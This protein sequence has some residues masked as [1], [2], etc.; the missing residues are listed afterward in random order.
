MSP[1][2]RNQLNPRCAR[3][4]LPRRSALSWLRTR[5]SAISGHHRR[6]PGR[7]DN[8][9]KNHLYSKLRRKF[10]STDP[11]SEEAKAEEARA[12]EAPS[13][14]GDS[15]DD[16]GDG[17]DDSDDEAAPGE[18]RIAS[19]RRPPAGAGTAPPARGDDPAAIG[20]RCRIRR[21]PASKDAAAKKRKRRKRDREK[22]GDEK[23][24]KSKK[25]KGRNEI[26]LRK[27]SSEMLEEH[28]R[29]MEQMRARNLAKMGFNTNGLMHGSPNYAELAM[30]GA[31][32]QG[33]GQGAGQ[34]GGVDP[35]SMQPGAAI[36]GSS[37][38]PSPTKRRRSSWPW[39]PS[40]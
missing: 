19:R 22:D 6:L 25:K 4:V 9:I 8:A 37:R 24:K 16:S 17:D 34:G 40:R 32:A 20:G 2:L 10:T 1:A 38:D 5:S 12:E 31:A 3:H 23:S 35:R 36:G 7:T 18:R 33:A 15:S 29:S 21:D 30:R 13:E 28:A 39:D 27:M 14:S 26:D 11:P